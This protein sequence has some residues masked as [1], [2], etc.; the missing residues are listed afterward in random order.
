[1]YLIQTHC[2]YTHE[3][4]KTDTQVT[5]RNLLDTQKKIHESPNNKLTAILWHLIHFAVA[6]KG[7]NYV[8]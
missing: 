6:F 7:K 2:F 8:K 1:M 4:E 3:Y 5:T